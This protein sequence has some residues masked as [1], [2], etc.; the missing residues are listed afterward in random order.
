MANDQKPANLTGGSIIVA[1][2][3]V[4]GA[5][6]FTHE[7]PLQ[8]SRPVMSEPQFHQSATSQDIET[9]LWQDPFAAVAKS[10]DSVEARNAGRCPENPD[11]PAPKGRASHCK[12][13]L[14]DADEPALEKTLVIGVMV[15]G[16]PYAED[17]EVRR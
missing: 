15:P 1:S 8:G 9:R 16:A 7:A 14:A 2:L 3:A 11:G 5:L 4:A 6:F 10:L 17:G 12:S 13:P